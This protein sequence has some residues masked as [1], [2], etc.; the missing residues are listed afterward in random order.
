MRYEIL[1][2]DGF[3]EL[4]ALGPWEILSRLA[5]DN[6]DVEAALVSLD[7]ERAVPASYG[8]VVRAQAAP[9]PAPDV[10]IVPGGGWNDRAP[11]GA[12]AEA[13]DGAL[14]ASSTPGTSSAPAA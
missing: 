2:Y 1:L 5:K 3:D 11:R 10:L 4:D 7:G 12:R 13:E 6:G 9:S 14:P 8:A